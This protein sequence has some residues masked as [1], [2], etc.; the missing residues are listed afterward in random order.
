MV[1][2]QN[3]SFSLV[4]RFHFIDRVLRDFYT[5]LTATADERSSS[6]RFKVMTEFLT[7]SHQQHGGLQANWTAVHGGGEHRHGRGRLPCTD[8]I[9]GWTWSWGKG[10]LVSCSCRADVRGFARAFASCGACLSSCH[11]IS[12]ASTRG[13]G[14]RLRRHGRTQR[15]HEQL[16]DCG[17]DSAPPVPVQT[18]STSTL[19]YLAHRHWVIS[20]SPS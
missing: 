6:G 11:R 17:T 8:Q 16:A 10:Y 5:T 18:V 14:G 12:D 9:S 13:S 20:L 2:N 3:E 15:R 1:R 19:V 4:D 7:A